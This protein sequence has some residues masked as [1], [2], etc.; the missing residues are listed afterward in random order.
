MQK[1]KFCLGISDI[2]DSYDGMIIDTEGVLHDGRKIFEGVVE[3]LKELRK[4]KKHIVFLVNSPELS[5]S[6]EKKLKPMGIRSKLY[7][8][9]ITSGQ[10][11]HDHLEAQD[12]GPFEDLGD[13]CYLYAAKG[14]SGSNED[15]P[16]PYLDGLD[17]DIVDDVKEA[18]FILI[19][20]FD[21]TMHKMSEVDKTLR[22]GVQRH[23]PAFYINPGSQSL[24]AGNFMMGAHMLALK[25][26]DFGGVV[27]F[28][29]K[30]HKLI[31]DYCKKGFLQ[32]EIYPGDMVM[33]G[34]TMAHDIAGGA[35]AN[36]DTALVKTGLHH[37]A[38][39]RADG[40]AET[41]RILNI[42]IAQNNN[43]RPGF[44]IDRFQWG[45]PLPDRKHRK[46]AQ[47]S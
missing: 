29:G 35:F 41:D 37:L 14:G 11:L 39:R 7:D 23:L 38:F 22:A 44:L 9:C 15:T 31:F 34:D 42:M 26:K 33:I 46:R 18:D 16:P 36:I 21:L 47:P 20:D 27:H 10:F 13:R 45:N 5:A 4:R 3:C 28:I 12:T 32:K 8:Q 6:I 17:I 40:P 2:S 25:Y 30:P 24:L 43:V 19:Q 1:T